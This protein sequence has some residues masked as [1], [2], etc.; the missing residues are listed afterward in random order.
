MASAV[1]GWFFLA[2]AAVFAALTIR[3][4]RR[5]RGAPSSARRAWLRIA[6]IFGLVGA[7]LQL[8]A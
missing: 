7:T 3:D 1:I 2:L 5:V 8:C 4:Y 6:L